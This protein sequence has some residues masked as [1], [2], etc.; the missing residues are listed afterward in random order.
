MSQKATV[1][2]A[3]LQEAS[4]GQDSVEHETKDIAS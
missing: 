3:A 2:T 4:K 1:R